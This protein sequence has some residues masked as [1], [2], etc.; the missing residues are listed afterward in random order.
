MRDIYENWNLYKEEVE[1]LQELENI[2]LEHSDEDMLNEGIVSKIIEKVNDFLL[3]VAMKIQSLGAKALSLVIGGFGVVDKF[4]KRNPKL[5][6]A[7][8]MVLTI[9]TVA[10]VMSYSEEAAAQITQG[11]EVVSQETVDAVRAK[12]KLMV[13]NDPEHSQVWLDIAAHIDQMHEAKTVEALEK[14]EGAL[15]KNAESVLNH[16]KE[17]ASEDPKEY[18]ALVD[19]GEKMLSQVEQGVASSIFDTS[20]FGKPEN[21][22]DAAKGFLSDYDLKNP[23]TIDFVEYG[24]A[25]KALEAYGETGKVPSDAPHQVQK[26]LNVMNKFLNDE[27]PTGKRAFEKFL[28]YGKTINIQAY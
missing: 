6:K 21:I 20:E 14:L 15:G 9:A 5:A 22:A 25:M 10:A 8:G 1:L 19:A 28:K 13:D 2:F 7:I 4:K 26:V 3:K 12:M 17:L 24:E 16:V 11:G 18:K 23:D 27:G